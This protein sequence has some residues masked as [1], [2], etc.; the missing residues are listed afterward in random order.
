V[1]RFVI[2][3]SCILYAAILLTVQ[4]VVGARRGARDVRRKDNPRTRQFGLA[5]TLPIIFGMAWMWHTGVE[6]L[7]ALRMTGF[8]IVSAGIF[9]SAWA[10]FALGPV[11]VG[12]VG[13]HRKHRIITSGPYRYVRHPLYTGMWISAI[14]LCVVSLNPAYGTGCL[15]FALAYTLRYPHEERLMLSRPK[16]SAVPSSE[17]P[18]LTTPPERARSSREWASSN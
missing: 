2:I 13:L 10:Q 11:W 8:V 1:L 18:T 16:L 14:G 12:G 5:S 7:I 9:V 15:M 17:W 4:S 6:N 3:Y